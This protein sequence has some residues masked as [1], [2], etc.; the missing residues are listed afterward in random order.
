[1]NLVS[2]LQKTTLQ[3]T[4]Y[5]IIVIALA[6]VISTTILGVFQ[7]QGLFHSI[8]DFFIGHPPVTKSEVVSVIIGGIEDKRPV[9]AG[10]VNY[11]KVLLLIG[12]TVFGGIDI[13]SY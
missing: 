3:Q 7:V 10:N 8:R 12:T 11:E 4:S 2:K 1:M 5:L 13:R 6:L 9:L